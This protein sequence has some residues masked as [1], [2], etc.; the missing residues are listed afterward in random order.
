M[1][2]CLD[3]KDYVLQF[4]ELSPSSYSDLEHSKVLFKLSIKLKSK[5]L[6]G[7]YIFF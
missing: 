2:I 3:L 4:V 5:P 1:E 7:K 6:V